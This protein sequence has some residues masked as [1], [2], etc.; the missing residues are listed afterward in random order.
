ME[1]KTCHYGEIYSFLKS[2]LA[3]FFKK[4]APIGLEDSVK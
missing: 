3:T 1:G 4:M 2:V